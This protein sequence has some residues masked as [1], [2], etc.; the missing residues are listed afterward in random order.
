MHLHLEKCSMCRYIRLNA[1]NVLN[2]HGPCFNAP[3]L[4]QL[5]LNTFLFYKF[6]GCDMG[7][8]FENLMGFAQIVPKYNANKNIY[9]KIINV[10]KHF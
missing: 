3:L 1:L 7:L 10:L 6:L 5:K 2:I 8:F 4:C 9:L